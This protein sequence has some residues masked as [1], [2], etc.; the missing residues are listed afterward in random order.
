MVERLVEEQLKHY[1]N[2]DLEA[3]VQVF[4]EDVEVY[5]LGEKAPYMVGRDAM[6]ERYGIRFQSKDL[7]ARIIHRMIKGNT[8]IDHEEVTG[9]GEDIVY[10]IAIYQ[11]GE[12]AIEKVWFVR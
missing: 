4:D 2:H 5:V 3:F 10:A 1:N 8:V 11:V 9:I 7:H 6:R 12:K